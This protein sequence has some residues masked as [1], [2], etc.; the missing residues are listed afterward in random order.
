MKILL[1]I[2]SVFLALILAALFYYLS[3]TRGVKLDRNKLHLN[4]ACVRVYDGTGEQIQTVS[5][6]TA[7][8][9]GEFPK[10]LPEAFVSVEDRKFYSHHGFDVK[11]ILKAA[12][13][14][15]V[16]FSFREGASTISQQLVKNTHLSGEKTISRKLKEFKLTRAL[17][18]QY[19]KEEIM[20]LYLNS[21]YFG[22]SA[23]GVGEAARFY[24]GKTVENLS[25]AECATLAALVKSPNRYSPFKNAE[26]C[27]ARRNLVLRFMNEQGYL[28]ESAYRTA[29][30]TPLPQTPV[31][32][33]RNAYLDRVY[34][35]LAELFPDTETGDASDMRV[36]TFFD[37]DLQAELEKTNAES[38]CCILVRDNDSN[39]LKALYATFGTPKRL[40]GS[41]IKP[42]LVYAPALEENL[43]TPLTPVLDKKTDFGGYSPDDYG[44]ASNDYVSVRR[45]IAK[46]V[47]IPAVKILNEL[48]IEKGV[49]Y[50]NKMNLRVSEDDY[51]LALALGGMK[52]GFTLPA[53]ADG[54]ATFANGGEYAQS[55]TIARVESKDGRVL[56]RFAPKPKRVFS[57]DVS[58]LMNDMLKSTVKEGT[59]KTLS[60]LAFPVCAKTG[61]CGTEAGNTDAYTVSYTKNHVVAVWLGNRDNTPVK[62]TGGGLPAN[63]ALRVYRAL[64]ADKKPDP[65]SD[66]DEVIAADYDLE[67]YKNEHRILLADPAAPIY[68]KG[69]ELFRKSALPAAT[70]EA[71]SR[72]KIEKPTI[73]TKNGAVYIELCHTQY[74]DYIIKRK[75]RGKITTI[76]NGKYQK[77]ICDNSVRQGETYTYTV[78]PVYQSTEGEG[79]ELPPIRIPKESS[80]PEDWWD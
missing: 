26:R 76:Y 25:P 67:I 52:E 62:A 39:G 36:Y 17:E 60:S 51:S 10:E 74:Y 48:G 7:V 79:V 8:P 47:N 43:I 71:F 70:S 18:K 44:G 46:S 32:D 54:Y 2:V 41:T 22:H 28:D 56:Y 9:Y 31:T 4:T 3:V 13:K 38:D 12:A 66:C 77:T 1:V 50:L 24:F 11:R 53:L 64:Y 29:L 23:F 33:N 59:A 57:K 73:Y 45:A 69:T 80:L 58:Y 30:Q 35:E 65:F 63:V 5:G 15:A 16:T 21:I 42:L 34:E 19:S 37:P 27:L 72:P 14:N 75:N 20:S 68:A 61:T 6:R 49:N 40:P 55:Q 78:V